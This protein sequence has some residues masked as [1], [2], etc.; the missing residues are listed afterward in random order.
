MAPRSPLHAWGTFPSTL[1]QLRSHGPWLQEHLGNAPNSHVAC[2]LVAPLAN[3]GCVH[4]HLSR[5]SLDGESPQSPAGKRLHLEFMVTNLRW[6]AAVPR[7]VLVP[8][9]SSSRLTPLNTPPPETVLPPASCLMKTA[10]ATREEGP[11]FSTRNPPHQLWVLSL[12]LQQGSCPPPWEGDGV[13][14]GAR[15]GSDPAPRLS[16]SRLL[17]ALCLPHP[18]SSTHCSSPVGVEGTEAGRLEAE[19]AQKGRWVLSWATGGSRN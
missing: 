13:G 2:L 1:S 7:H 12:R 10:E 14:S 16:T 11:H 9:S 17:G 18:V 4:L 5:L 19:G 8:A 3:P 15:R 6:T